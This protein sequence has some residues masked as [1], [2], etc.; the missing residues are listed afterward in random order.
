MN[1]E[2]LTYEESMHYLV[3]KSNKRAWT[4]AVA[5][6]LVSVL[7]A[8][9]IMLLTP[10]K[11]V[12]PYVIKVNEETGNV[13][14]MTSLDNKKTLPFQTVMDKAEANRYVMKRIG[15][16][17]DTLESDY[18]YVMLHST[19]EVAKVYD[20]EIRGKNGRVEK[21]KDNFTKEVNII[22]VVPGKSA[23]LNNMTVRAKI[24]VINKNIGEVVDSYKMI[25][26]IVYKYFNNAELSEKD[27][28]INPFAYKVIDFIPTREI[29]LKKDMP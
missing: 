27:R 2:A 15:Y 10:I 19:E 5:S 8:A 28:L 24:D 17:Y 4:V 7:L 23:D 29:N 9:A 1:K 26:T 20:K 25:Y 21:L 14:I 16:H 11:T 6:L 3:Q 22:S 12:V 18:Y 13:E